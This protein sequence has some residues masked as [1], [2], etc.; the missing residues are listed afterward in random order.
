MKYSATELRKNIYSVLDSVLDTGNPVEIVR[1]GK[2]L[3]LVAG[4]SVSRLDRLEPHETVIG[5]PEGLED[6]H[7]DGS[8][9][10]PD[11]PAGS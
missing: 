5:S 2:S 7:W 4:D 10:G 11:L 6:I 9:T 1:H 3:R 8:W